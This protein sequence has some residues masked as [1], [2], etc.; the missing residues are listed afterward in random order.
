[1]EA[2]LTSMGKF[3]TKLLPTTYE[4]AK[5]YLDEEL[6]KPKG[7]RDIPREMC[8]LIVSDV[9]DDQDIVFKANSMDL[10]IRFKQGELSI[11]GLHT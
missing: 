3:P 9:P 2:V 1:M 5:A 8:M 7:Q 4:A 6:L 11:Y 10:L